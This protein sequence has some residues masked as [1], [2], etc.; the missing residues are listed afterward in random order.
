[1]TE[2]LSP[3]EIADC[4]GKSVLRAEHRHFVEAS[5]DNRDHIPRAT[6]IAGAVGAAL[7]ELGLSKH[8]SASASAS[9]L[10]FTKELFLDEWICRRSRRARIPR[11][12]LPRERKSLDAV[13][14]SQAR[15]GCRLERTIPLSLPL[16]LLLLSFLLLL[17]SLLPL[18]SLFL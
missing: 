4:I 15:D 12:C 7:R 5:E 16:L 3:R 10:E 2:N 6:R 1:M 13:W 9:L 17:V 18:L 8:E 11:W 14:S